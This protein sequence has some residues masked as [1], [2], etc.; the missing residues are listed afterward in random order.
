MEVDK[1]YNI[2]TIEDIELTQVPAKVFEIFA[3]SDS[4]ARKYPEKA[5]SYD[6][7]D[8]FQ[9]L[10]SLERQIHNTSVVHHNENTAG[11]IESQVSRLVEA[12]AL[13]VN[14]EK[15]STIKT[16]VTDAQ[17]ERI[18]GL[19]TQ[20]SKLVEC[21]TK[22]AS[23]ESQISNLVKVL[24]C[25]PQPN[26]LAPTVHVVQ[27]LNQDRIDKIEKQVASLQKENKCEIE[28]ASSNDSE[29]AKIPVRISKL[30]VNLFQLL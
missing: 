1:S 17:T 8:I 16:S 21:V 12:M 4:A 22:G 9:R 3:R 15:P 27:S 10:D 23:L 25:S 18:G 19:E 13:S 29:V 2:D 24:S 7:V 11:R 30:H 14:N 20:L 5:E 6:S 28:Y 26:P